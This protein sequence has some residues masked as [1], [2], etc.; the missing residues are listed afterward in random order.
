MIAGGM[1]VLQLILLTVAVRVAVLL[2]AT[3]SAHCLSPFDSSGGNDVFLRWD[4]VH[5]AHM[6]KAGYVYEHEWAFLYGLPFLIRHTPWPLMQLLGLSAN[7]GSTYALYHMSL[8]MMGEKIATL[9][10]LLSLLP[11]SPATLTLA[12]YNEPFFTFLSYMGTRHPHHSTLLIL[13]QECCSVNE[14]NLQRRRC[15]SLWPVSFAPTVFSLLVFSFGVSSSC[16]FL[17]AHLCVYPPRS[18]QLPSSYHF[19]PIMLPAI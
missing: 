5:F 9:A 13:L 1:S 8:D 16:H 17:R 12:P 15:I 7:I 19:S 18:M 14:G 4:A 2:L 11:S 3:F 6:A 10:T